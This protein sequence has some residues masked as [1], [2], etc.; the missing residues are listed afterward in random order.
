MA[1]LSEVVSYTN[2]Y[3]NVD[4][5]RDYCP[6]GLQV[7]GK[8][9][10]QTI[11]SGVSASYE[12]FQK[13]H[14]HGADLIL[15]HHGILWGNEPIVLSGSFKRRI[16]YLLTHEMT[17]L[18][19]HLPLDA[20]KEVG[21]N[22]MVAKHLGLKD[23]E[24]FANYKANEIGFIGHLD[25]AIS[26]KDFTGI[27]ESVFQSKLV[28]YPFGKKKIQRVGIVTGGAEEL[29]MSAIE[30][31]CDLYITGEVGEPTL[32]LAKEEEINFIAAGH[33]NTEKFG[34]QALGQQIAR[35][36]NVKHLF[37]D[38]PNAV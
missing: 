13:A 33:Y 9:D 28:S 38:V 25:E 35:E 10:V 17:L 4:Q 26:Y 15:V 6:N 1:S 24:S 2:Q 23:L 30:K 27:V 16:K 22:A 34:V 7:E 29:I 11:I 36:M 19:Y 14:E 32:H 37:I 5:Y 18:A 21:N 3:L 8:S 12:L 20:H 31:N